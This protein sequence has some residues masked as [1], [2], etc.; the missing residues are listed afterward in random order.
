[1]IQSI[2]PFGDRLQMETLID[3]ERTAHAGVHAE[4]IETGSQVAPDIAPVGR[5]P[6]GS[7]LNRGGAGHDIKGQWRIILQHAG[8]L[9]AVAEP[10][11]IRWVSGLCRRTPGGAAGHRPSAPNPAR[12]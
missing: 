12:R 8:Q 6:S 1:M 9:K 7:P 11:P 10:L 4:D 3:G 5:G 2:E